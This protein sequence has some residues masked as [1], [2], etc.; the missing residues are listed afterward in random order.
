[1]RLISNGHRCS[2]RRALLLIAIVWLPG[3]GLQL[4]RYLDRHRALGFAA[5]QDE[6]EANHAWQGR[7]VSL[8]AGV[9]QVDGC[10]AGC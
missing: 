2:W 9:N 6:W 10:G 3:L 7:A 1:M 4:Q 5:L 8:I